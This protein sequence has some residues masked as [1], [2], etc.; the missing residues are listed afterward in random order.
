MKP[1][2]L[3]TSAYS[4]H[5]PA[6]SPHP[7]GRL[8][9][10]PAFAG[11]AVA[12][13]GVLMLEACADE[14]PTAPDSDQPP[15]TTAL[16]A[17]QSAT[18]V[19]VEPHWLT[20]DT[21]GVTGTLAAT[22]IDA[23]G[24][25]VDGVTVTWA[26]LDT[27][28][29]TVD[30]EGVVTS[31]AFGSTKVTASYE[32]AV[33]EATVEVAARLTDR[34]ILEILYEAAGGDD[35]TDNT[36]WLSDEDLD[37][38]Y[39]VSLDQ[40]RV[41]RLQ[42][43]ENNLVGT[44]PPELGGLDRLEHLA[45]YR[46]SLSGP[47]P[48]SLAK[49]NRLRELYPWGNIEISGELPP[50]L[51][52]LE[53]L[54]YLNVD[55]TS[56]SG[57]V[58][59]TFANLELIRLYFDEEL[60]CVPA[61]M[62]EWLLAIPQANDE[63]SLCTA[64]IH[65]DPS[66][67]IL[68]AL[69]DTAT[70]AATI[71]DADGDTVPD[72]TVTWSSADTAIA[73]IDSTGLVT[74]IEYGTTEVTASS[75][76]LTATA[77][78][79]VGIILTDREILEIFY[80]AT[81]GDDW[82]DNTNWLS[83]EDLSEWFGVDA[84]Q[85]R[86][87]TLELQDNNLVG[88]IPPELGG[89]DEL[90]II[91][92]GRNSLS[93]SIPAE[94]GRLSKLRDFFVPVNADLSG[95]LPPELGHIE[96]F[97]N[98]SVDYTGLD[99][100]VPRT[101]ANLDLNRFY[102]DIS[103]ICIPAEL[104]EWLQAIPQRHAEYELCTAS[105]YVRPSS[106][107]LEAPGDAARLTADVFNADGDTVPDATVTWSSADTL[108]ATVDTTGLVTAIEYGITEVTAT[109][110]SLTATAAVQVGIILTDREILEVFYEATGGDDWT[111]NTNWLS[112]KD[113]SEWHGVSAYQGKVSTVSLR[114]NNLTGTIPRELGDLD[115]LFIIS[116]NDNSLTGSIPPELG[117]LN[118]LRDLYLAGNVGISGGLPP[119]LGHME[120]LLYVAIDQTAIEGPIP[121][122]YANLELQQ[123]YFETS[124]ICV[125]ADLEAWLLAIPGTFPNYELCTANIYVRP[126]SLILESPGDTA[127]LAA[128]VVNADGD[129]VPDAMVTWS[130]ADTTVATVD[131][132]GLVTG[133]EFGSTEITATS[134]SLAAVAEVDV[135]IPLTDR[136]IL[137]VLYEATNG[138]DWT[139]NTNWLSDKDLEEWYGVRLTGGGRVR[140]LDLERNNLVGTIPSELG[141]LDELTNLG[142]SFN[143]L[144]GPIP[145]TLGKLDKVREFYLIGNTGISGGLPPELGYM[146]GLEYLSVNGTSLSG[147]V[148]Q[149]FANLELIR[150]RFDSDRVCIPAALE[151]WLQS[152]PQTE[153]EYTLC[154]A[155][156]HIEPSSLT[157]ES[158]GDTATLSATVI[159]AE[160]DTL[161]DAVVTWSSADTAVA[162]VD[163]T[164]LVTAVAIGSTTVTATHELASAEVT[165]E[166]VAP[167]TNREV[168]EILYAATRG[169][170]WGNNTN[171]LSNKHLGEWYGVNTARDAVRELQLQDNNM[172]G[173]IP[174]EL[175]YLDQLELLYVDGNSLSGTVPAEL[176]RLRKLRELY[177]RGNTE[178]TGELPP[179]LGYLKTLRHLTLEATGLHGSVPQTFA[180]LELTR[181]RFDPDR[182]CVPPSLEEWLQSIEKTVD[183]YRLCTTRIAIHPRSLQLGAPPL[184]DTARLS[185]TVISAEGDTVHGAPITWESADPA[186]A[187]VS[188]TG[189][190]TSIGYGA[191]EVIAT[192]G[193][194]SAT[195]EVEI[196]LA[197]S[198]RQILDSIYRVTGGENWTNNTNWLSDEDLSEWYGVETNEAGNVVALSL[199]GNNLT[200][201]IP[202]LFAE[203]RD[204]VTLDLRQNA[205]EGMI[206]SRLSELRQLRDLFL[207][208][209]AL[210]GRLPSAMG[211]MGQLRH[212]HIAYNK[213]SG[214]VPRSFADLALQSFY[215]ADSGACLPPSLNVWYF[216][217]QHTDDVDQCIAHIAIDVVDLP[218]LSFYTVGETATLAATH[219][220]AEGYR[221]PGVTATWSSG[222]TGVVTVDRSGAVTAVG[223]G[224]TDVTAAFDA[225]TGT[226]AA[227]VTPP[228]TDRE[229]LEVL[230]DRARGGAW[231]DANNW[232]TDAPLSEWAGV[233]TDDE[234]RVVGLSLGGNNLRGAFHS[235]IGRLDRLVTLDLSRNW[236]TGPVPVEMGG[237]SM[238]RDLVLSANGFVGELPAELGALSDLRSLHVA[239][240]SIS[241]RV[242]ASFA[243]LELE[244]FLVNGTG[245]C[246]PPS[247][248]GWLES[249]PGTDDPPACT[250][251]VTISPAPV[252]FGAIGDTVGLT[253]TVVGPDG[254][255]VESPAV[256]WESGDTTVA[257]VDSTGLVTA[258]GV[259]VATVT[260]T[261]ESVTSGTVDVAVNPPGS[262][263]AVL[264]AFYHASGG[265]DW[266]NNAN[267]L[268]DEPL[269]TWFGVRTTS[270]G[271]VRHLQLANNN[272]TG[273]FPAAVG[274]LDS[275]VTLDFHRNS[276]SGAIPPAVGRL[277]RLENL[278]LAHNNLSGSLPPE[279]GNLAGLRSLELY[280][281]GLAGP[282]P[283]AFANLT[284]N[285]FF[286]TGS[287]LCVPRSLDSWFHTIEARDDK[288]PPCIPSTPDRDVLVEFYN[289]TGGPGWRTSDDWLTDKSLDRW[290]G[291]A[292]DA[293]GYVTEIFMPG[294][295]L[296]GEVPPALGDLRRL[297]VLA[298][299]SN[300]LTGEI[301]PELGKL[302]SLRYLS[303]S[304]NA[305]EG[306][307]PP[308]LGNLIN[309]DTIWLPGNRLSGPIPP[310]FG[311]LESLEHL[312]I[313]ENDLSGPLPA[314]MGNLT[315]L[316][317]LLAVG[318]KLEGPLP[319]ELGDM[320]SLERLS[321]GDN[322]ITGALPPELGKLRA[323]KSLRLPDNQRDRSRPSSEVWLRSRKYS[324]CGT[325]CRA[326][327][328]PSWA[329][330]RSWRS[331]GSSRIS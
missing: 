146:E 164:G 73:A 301:P 166:Y 3:R 269:G 148:P 231:T 157:L 324:W 132:A 190:V 312:A 16:G 198:D 96:T 142:L 27:A 151:A 311:K 10:K 168:L 171:W 105:I 204:L 84:D 302:T 250:G 180:N 252:T 310:E 75:D 306:P 48:A 67:L 94:L 131:T 108:I 98:I 123:F 63:Y 141:D 322:L 220:D 320:T 214:V 93:G 163:T 121:R 279:M 299:W 281:T 115:E 143:V 59:R 49:L 42:L 249:I 273:A 23:A 175:Q 100:P 139:D 85:G 134:D 54:R 289:A 31:V 234:G 90:Y 183:N 256:T 225:A 217:I 125:P 20:L 44:I 170:N 264:E 243:D 136:E 36:N 161:A 76:S 189:L 153:D 104:E 101:W 200:D 326:A 248:A 50:E 156:V 33:G 37:E 116:L 233:E 241:G 149:T 145:A 45:L 291:I 194:I 237:L 7:Y 178:L 202:G 292:T 110:D 114:D 40:G 8:R 290:D 43:Q 160:G 179:E 72:V 24:D 135:G 242:P 102:F 258:R 92:L 95:G 203:L 282:I 191:T 240:T 232:M 60:L 11:L 327:F 47:L 62:E 38:W 307:I 221:T 228:E 30:T 177:M 197:L 219:V 261:H 262:E 193:S 89:L 254:D 195:A 127:T 152:I 65:V 34:E 185:A 315:N 12:L 222:N 182:I 83:D 208:D 213:L 103:R 266:T 293:E 2:Y 106:L 260:A 251:Q 150:F 35:W 206:P 4:P 172:A 280:N 9:P 199:S 192:S 117:K 229:V 119:E 278:F 201:S 113:L 239:A 245:V 268:S 211:N 129:I 207:E 226:I 319:P 196:V 174:P 130:S 88:S 181:F 259:G 309:A 297:E 53:G 263:R 126:P 286:I 246:V 323:L 255:V 26:S 274:L 109:S 138:D 314:E 276:L 298:L 5:S 122:T 29:A 66:S 41:S 97:R 184:G 120:G 64:S 288:V 283:D 137:E 316:K 165:V 265:D 287:G 238:L 58:P 230:H 18:Q 81:G 325:T 13:L 19:V 32:S 87:T 107:L 173:T 285:H 270:G 154:T 80:E 224:V 118:R 215:A 284:L 51:G 74:A 14:T 71:I 21:I 124:R 162:T 271:R 244:S 15:A 46:N 317:T 52:Y 257:S 69:G 167:F 212:L 147:P 176:G 39:G 128:T 218:S 91:A 99:G 330:C 247:L 17:A 277:R 295:G 186:I 267:W 56:L 329:I 304:G 111:D 70:L 155:M 82:I 86:V 308:E 57:R 158:A 300:R 187:T 205:L 78:V 209:N 188:A 313:F 133:V 169:D 112:D 28:I 253:A 223:T 22:V 61:D 25:T 294:N 79:Q 55:E 216:G 77:T 296:E 144:S 272:L 140:R 227:R 210:E 321:L 318:N 305:L 275:I 235:S 159:N 328:H 236:L 303:L 68:A 6:D 1:L 331:C